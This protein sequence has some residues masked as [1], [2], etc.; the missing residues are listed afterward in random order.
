MKKIFTLGQR[1]FGEVVIG[2][3]GRGEWGS[4]KNVKVM[5]NEEEM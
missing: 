5:Q 2:R 4:F 3:A 1:V